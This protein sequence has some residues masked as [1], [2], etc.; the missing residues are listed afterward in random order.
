MERNQIQKGNLN[1]Y[2]ICPPLWTLEENAFYYKAEPTK[3][4]DLE[5]FQTPTVNYSE[6][7]AANVNL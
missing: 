7:K 6:S 2:T 3:G 1:T 5:L 4:R